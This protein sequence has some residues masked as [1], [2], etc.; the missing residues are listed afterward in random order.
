MKKKKWKKKT[1]YRVN[2]GN[3]GVIN[4]GA[5]NQNVHMVRG[6]G[7]LKPIGNYNNHV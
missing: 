6:G 2:A 1:Q 3:M 4:T 7:G 5:F